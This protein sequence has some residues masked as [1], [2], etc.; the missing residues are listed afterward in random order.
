MTL[1][2]VTATTD[3][4]RA[5]PC[6]QSWR[7]HASEP[8]ELYIC[9]NGSAPWKHETGLALK[10]RNAVVTGYV[11]TVTAFRAGVDLALQD[12][13]YRADVI[14]CLHDDFEIQQ[15]G[16]DQKV[17][18]H[19]ER[20]PACGLAGFGGAIGLGAEDIYQTPYD[21]MQLA[22]IGFRSDLVDA[23]QH[24]IRSLLPERIACLDGFSQIGRREFWQGHCVNLETAV[25]LPTGVEE[26]PWHV[27]E[28][29]GVIHHGYDGMLGCLAAR[30]GWEVWYLPLRAHH[31]GGRTAVG[32]T[33][34]QAWAKTKHPEGDAGLWAEAHQI[35]YD[36]FRDVL[37]LRV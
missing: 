1:A 14:A 29:L 2:V 5:V 28:D 30:Y 22:R 37:P 23:E 20:Y 19:F 34:Y 10:I 36:H 4:E 3:L 11:G 33:G 6:L 12:S 13:Q 35:W 21:P 15:A 26:P 9:I 17:Q 16:W 24:G 8:Y 27:L 31:H 7:Q 18:R 32:D 25:R